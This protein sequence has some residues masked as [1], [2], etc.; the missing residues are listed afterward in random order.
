MV[1]ERSVNCVNWKWKVDVV[2]VAFFTFQLKVGFIY[3]SNA[4]I[5]IESTRVYIIITLK[6]EIGN[7][8]VQSCLL[9]MTFLC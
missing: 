1:D 2:F 7:V 3:R 5:N 6:L 4:Y 8:A 9:K